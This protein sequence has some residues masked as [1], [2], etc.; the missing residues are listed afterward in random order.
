MSKEQRELVA[1]AQE[2]LE[3]ARLLQ[4]AGPH[5]FAAS[6]A[7]YGMFYIAEALLL[8]EGLAF[9]KHGA[10]HA[11][12]GREFVKTGIVERY[13]HQY[14]VRAMAV[15]HAGDYGKYQSVTREEATKQIERAAEFL[16]LAD[17][18]LATE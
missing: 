5:G 3:A 17:R 15:R 12:F 13:F 16:R 14:L 2:S 8:G 18:L 10:V 1:R 9:S 7:Y 11:A 6:R 4:E